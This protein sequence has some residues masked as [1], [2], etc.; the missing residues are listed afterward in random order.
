VL[1]V[2]FVVSVFLRSLRATIV[3]AVPPWCRCLALSA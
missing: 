3:P 1:L 2:V